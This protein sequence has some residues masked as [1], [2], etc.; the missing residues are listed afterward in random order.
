VK[1]AALAGTAS[2]TIRPGTERAKKKNALAILFI[3]RIA[4]ARCGAGDVL[5][6]CVFKQ[7][8]YSPRGKRAGRRNAL[9]CR[10]P[11]R[12]P[13]RRSHYLTRRLLGEVSRIFRVEVKVRKWLT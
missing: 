4:V 9:A 10:R 1:V 7:S 11:D 13:P 5:S 8:V 12:N 2:A 3:L 6:A